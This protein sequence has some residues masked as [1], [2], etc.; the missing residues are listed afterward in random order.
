[1]TIYRNSVIDDGDSARNA[2]QIATGTNQLTPGGAG[3][4]VTIA[5]NGF[6]APGAIC[7]VQYDRTVGWTTANAGFLSSIYDDSTDEWTIFSSNVAD[8]NYVNWMLV[9]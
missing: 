7:L 2:V 6:P 4:F 3:G 1:M 5:L 8:N 9:R